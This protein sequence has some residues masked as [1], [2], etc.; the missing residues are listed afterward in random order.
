M[1]NCRQS[2]ESLRPYIPGK[3][4][5][6][7]KQEYGLSQVIKLASNENPLGCSDKAK[8][9]IVNALD[10]VGIY[11]DGNASYLRKALSKELN[12]TEEQLI[13][14][15]GSDE[16]ITFITQ[17]YVGEGDE[18]I[19]CTP[20]FPR[21]A[22]AVKLMGGHIIEVPLKNYTFDLNGIVNAITDKTKVIFIANPNNPT[23]TIITKEEQLDFLKKVPKNI[24]VVMDEAYSEY[25][26]DDIFPDTL[27]I[28]KD[29]PNL[30]ILKTFS[31][32]YG[33]ASLRV[34]Y[35]IAKESII[36][37]LNRVRG[38]F[39]VTTLA[40]NAALA[41]LKDKDFL[42]QSIELNTTIK[43]WTYEKCDALGLDYIPTFGNFIMIH[44]GVDT[45]EV[46]QQLQSKGIIVRPGCFLGLEG[47]LRVTLGTQEQ[48]ALFF[49]K[50]TDILN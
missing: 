27:S 7:V 2:I 48:M 21:Y 9:A 1:I 50:L 37:L 39:N 15:A 26:T 16:I 13:F 29:Y 42:K 36:E 32:A 41:S 25:I 19:T 14:G 30:I 46:F 6:D 47:W 35:G 22:S 20:S 3:P 49:E 8:E 33:L 10:E 5:N 11:P 43:E 45:L 28:L 12:V 24:L 34:G 44:I 18:A 40:Q 31:K 17:V 23:G 4:I 38:P